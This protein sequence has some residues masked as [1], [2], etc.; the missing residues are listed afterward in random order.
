MAKIIVRTMFAR[1]LVRRC[2]MGGKPEGRLMAAVISQAAADAL[3]SPDQADREEAEQ[4]F[5]D[6]RMDEWADF[7]GIHP[8]FVRRLFMDA[9]LANE[10]QLAISM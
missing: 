6:G 8:D 3:L 7:A 2:E 9:M 5:L 1:V 10:T 4:F